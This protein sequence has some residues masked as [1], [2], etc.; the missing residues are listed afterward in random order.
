MT[1]GAGSSMNERP[2]AS[3]DGAASSAAP[4]VSQAR[5]G[6]TRYEAS[7]L[8]E[9]VRRVVCSVRTMAFA[10]LLAFVTVLWIF[11]RT[12][13]GQ[14][15]DER[16]RVSTGASARA[17]VLIVDPLTYITI[18]TVALALTAFVIIA[19]LRRRFALALA[20]ILVVAGANIT[21][22][23]F[24]AYWPTSPHYWDNS[25]PSGHSTVAMSVSVAAILVAPSGARRWLL[26]VTA[27]GATFVGAGTIVGHWHRPADVWA[28]FLVCLLWSAGA[29]GF[30]LKLQHRRHTRDAK[31]AMR[32]ALGIVGAILTGLVFVLLGVRPLS[33]DIKLVEATIALVGTGLLAA[34]VLAWVSAAADDNLG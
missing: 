6:A 21:T 16:G 12:T 8:P 20:A 1:S 2:A 18:A 19:L 28:A 11:T 25:L 3:T 9:P 34:L 5:R 31:Y 15:W 29:I 27:F 7:D 22:Q 17:W 13:R 10:S 4:S 14:L 24:K 30:V 26:P 33:H 32:P 23:L